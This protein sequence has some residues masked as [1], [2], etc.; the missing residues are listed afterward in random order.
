MQVMVTFFI[1]LL[2]AACVEAVEGVGEAAGAGVED[3]VSIGV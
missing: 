2:T 1:L 3:A